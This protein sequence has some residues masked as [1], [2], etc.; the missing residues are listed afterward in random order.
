[1]QYL[2]KISVL[3]ICLIAFPAPSSAV[4]AGVY[5]DSGCADGV[6]CLVLPDWDGGYFDAGIVDTGRRRRVVLI[7]DAGAEVPED[8]AFGCSAT[9]A[10]SMLWLLPLL[11]VRRR[12]S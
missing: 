5:P 6:C 1:M 2:I 4:D 8:G 12:K 3:A 11:A 7:S 9:G 10:A